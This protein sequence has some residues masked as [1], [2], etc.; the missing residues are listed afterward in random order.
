RGRF[1]EATFLVPSDNVER[2]AALWPQHAGHGVSFVRT[3]FPLAGRLWT[4]AKRL[5]IPLLKGAPFPLP[6]PAWLREQ[7]ASVDAVLAIGGD[8]YSLDY[9]IP[10]VTQALDAYAMDMGKP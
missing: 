9:R 1:P 5:P 3:Y 2:D 4:H 7:L 10:V 6:A 8:N